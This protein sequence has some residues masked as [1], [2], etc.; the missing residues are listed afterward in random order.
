VIYKKSLPLVQ[1]DKNLINKDQL[2]EEL[3]GL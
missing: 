3:S 2:K 1:S